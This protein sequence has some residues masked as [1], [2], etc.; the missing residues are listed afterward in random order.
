MEDKVWE[1]PTNKLDSVVTSKSKKIY[2]VVGENG[3][4]V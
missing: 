2:K 1:N 3:D 4:I